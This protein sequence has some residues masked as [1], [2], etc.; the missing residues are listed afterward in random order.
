M[1]LA[2][3]KP[4]TDICLGTVQ[5]STGRRSCVE[6]ASCR[7][8]YYW[9][10]VGKVLVPR[11]GSCSQRSLKQAETEAMLELTNEFP[12]Q[13]CRAHLRLLKSMSTLVSPH[14]GPMHPLLWLERESPL[15]PGS[16]F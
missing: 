5:P 11:R 2:A 12:P 10:D 6:L 7:G 13:D 1:C 9:G 8:G 16:S 4:Q 3:A 15:D 14:T